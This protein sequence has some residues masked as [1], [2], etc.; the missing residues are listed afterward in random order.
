MIK[1]LRNLAHLEGA[2]SSVQE[3]WQ[4]IDM[5]LG[6]QG[7]DIGISDEKKIATA[8]K[9]YC[10]RG[11]APSTKLKPVFDDTAASLKD[12]GY[13]YRFDLPPP[14][15]LDAFDKMLATDVGAEDRAPPNKSDA[16]QTA[17]PRLPKPKKLF[18]TRAWRVYVVA[19]VLWGLYFSWSNMTEQGLAD[20]ICYGACRTDEAAVII[21]A[22]CILMFLAV[23]AYR[24]ILRGERD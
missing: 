19:C 18:G 1:V 7:R 17:G 4:I 10:G 21:G 16:P 2:S 9:A 6:L 12:Q 5:W 11:L 14:I 3:C 13:D 8:W 15:V 22:G 24:W 23:F 20:E